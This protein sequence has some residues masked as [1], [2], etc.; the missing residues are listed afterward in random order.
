MAVGFVRFPVLLL[1]LHATVGDLIA[2]GAFVLGLRLA[3]IARS[4]FA[5]DA[6]GSGT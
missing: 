1:M 2:I 5:V 3:D 6:K 4:H